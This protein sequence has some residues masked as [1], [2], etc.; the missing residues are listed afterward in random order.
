MPYDDHVLP[1]GVRSRFIRNVNGLTF[2]ILEAGK[3]EKETPVVLL[4]HGFPELAYSW[5]KVMPAL[6]AEGYYVVAPD[7]RGFGRTTGWYDDYDTDLTPFCLD[8]HVNDMMGLMA[9]L[10]RSHVEAVIGHDAGASVTAC[11][12]LIRPDVFRAAVMMSAPFTGPPSG[13]MKPDAVHDDLAN[14][15][16]P[17]KHYHWYY[18]TR[19][20][21]ADMRR[22]PQGVHDFMRAYYHHKSADWAHNQP[23]PLSDWSAPELA[24]MPTY[25]IMDLNETMAATVAMEMPTPAQISANT[26]LPDKDLMIYSIEYERTGYQGGLNWY[27]CRTEGENNKVLSQYAGRTIDVPTAFIAGTSDWGIQQVPG[28][29]EKMQAEA[30]TDFRGCY[31]VDG[32]GHWVQQ[33]QADAVN[34]RL[35]EFLSALP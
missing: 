20:A 21:N 11:C 17:R 7:L 12:A 33:E 9:A 25:Y 18:S 26:W 1:D 10:E 35:I 34:A 16:R 24:K 14:L 27:R 8:N 15:D 22:C 13:D 28:A 3:P 5:R 31:L 6:A 23:L 30:C 29:L 19:E 32:A 2:H 4:L